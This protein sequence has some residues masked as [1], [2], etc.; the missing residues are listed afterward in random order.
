MHIS[1]IDDADVERSD[2]EQT[3]GPDTLRTQPAALLT[4]DAGA[5]PIGRTI[6][7]RYEI[8]RLVGKGGMGCVFEAE[9]LDLGRRVALKLVDWSLARDP[10]VATRIKQEAR[11]T[12]AIESEHIVQVFDA[13]DDAELGVFLV[14][15]LLK[16]E[17][18]A[19]LLGRERALPQ[20]VAAGLIA[21][22]A[23]GLARA[24]SAGI[25]HRD[26]KPANVFVCTRE[27]GGSLVKLV[28]FG[29][30]KLLRDA[31]RQ[32]SGLTQMGMVVGT[33][34]YMSPEQAQGLDVDHRSDIYSLGAVLYEAIVGSSPYPERP[35][36]EQ[37]ILQI[38]L[39][40]CPRI[41]ELVPSVHP[42]LDQLCAEMMAPT[43]DAR[44]QE[45]T[46]VRDRL[47]A[48]LAELGATPPRSQSVSD[49]IGFAAT[50]TP[51]PS[52]GAIPLSLE[53]IRISAP[54]DGEL[55][56]QHVVELAI[57]PAQT[58][59]KSSGRGIV[60][61]L[62]ALVAVVGMVAFAGRGVGSASAATA[63]V[64]MVQSVVTLPSER[65]PARAQVPAPAARPSIPT[66][67]VESLPVAKK[68]HATPTPTPT[69]TSTSTPTSTPTSKPH[70]TV[71]SS[72]P[73]GGTFESTTF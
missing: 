58:V 70:D 4:D 63:G 24:H 2:G 20:S 44:P 22:A 11:S 23:K 35:T 55:S 5:Q 3:S 19:A 34:Q 65:E 17:D 56:G 64:G 72:R 36:Y 7:G 14:M 18:L 30:A 33:P 46:I 47:L 25:V 8:K 50:M 28:D 26:L 68:R 66:V 12:G 52:V 73:V 71:P 51:A 10:Q 16:G 67:S 6:Q 54:S 37:T 62:L 49:D 31:S 32:A 27:D 61:A 21:Q 45:M 41:S 43:P 48:I 42:D 59:Q 69:P 40:P 1:D 29:I 57:E 15:E 60:G 13:G 53:R 38:L 9:H 39:T